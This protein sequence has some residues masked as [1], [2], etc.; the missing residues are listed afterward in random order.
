MI[1]EILYHITWEKRD[2]DKVKYLFN[3]IRQHI[4]QLL[5]PLQLFDVLSL[6]NDGVLERFLDLI[7]KY[8]NLWILQDVEMIH[9]LDRSSPQTTISVNTTSNTSLSQQIIIPVATFYMEEIICSH[10]K[11]LQ[12]IIGILVNV[13]H[14]SLYYHSLHKIALQIISKWY[15]ASK[16]GNEVLQFSKKYVE[17]YMSCVALLFEKPIEPNLLSNAMDLFKSAFSFYRLILYSDPNEDYINHL[18]KILLLIGKKFLHP[19]KYSIITAPLSADEFA[20]IFANTLFALVTFLHKQQ[21]W[22]S[23]KF[24]LVA[25][26]NWLPVLYN[27]SNSLWLLLNSS[28][29]YLYRKQIANSILFKSPFGIEFNVDLFQKTG[30]RSLFIFLNIIT[31]IG[32][33]NSIEKP[34]YHHHV[35]ESLVVLSDSVKTFLNLS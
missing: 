8:L 22:E 30:S 25:S 18:F 26:T 12:P 15:N 27:W 6:K 24:F 13:L 35:V 34:E 14:Q 7:T 2:Y 9:I 29:N 11:H 28:C 33:I 1:S 23:L 10:S 5:F 31:A 16:E 3:L 19:L 20:D 21:H 17:Y 32:D 4:L